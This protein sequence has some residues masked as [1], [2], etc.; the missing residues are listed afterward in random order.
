M[1]HYWDEYDEE[2]IDKTKCKCSLKE[3]KSKCTF[4]ISLGAKIPDT[5]ELCGLK[6]DRKTKRNIRSHKNAVRA[7]LSRKAKRNSNNGV[8]I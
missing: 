7:F 8:K 5:C 3:I 6:F 4:D 2:P 1:W